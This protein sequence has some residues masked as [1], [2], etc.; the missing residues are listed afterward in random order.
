LQ[1]EAPPESLRRLLTAAFVLT[2]LRVPREVATNVFQGV[3][4][5]K[6]SD[7]YMAILDEGREIE[8]RKWLLFQGEERFGAPEE[9]VKTRLE[10]ITDLERLERLGRR[11]LRASSW[12]ELLETP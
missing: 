10:S 4:A 11:L 6:D 9:S 1:R 3:R 12:Q 7:T 2:G 5:M 8:A